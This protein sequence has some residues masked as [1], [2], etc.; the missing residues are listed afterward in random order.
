MKRVHVAVAVAEEALGRLQEVAAMCRALGFDHDWTLTTVG[1]L[2][3]SLDIDRLAQ[4]RAVPGVVAVEIARLIR[5][6][7]LRVAADENSLK[8]RRAARRAN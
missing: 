4:L 5:P 1:V 7:R 6:V 8:E 3:G 2:T